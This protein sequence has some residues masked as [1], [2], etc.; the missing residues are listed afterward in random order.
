MLEEFS[1]AQMEFLRN[2]DEANKNKLYD[3][4][5]KFNIDSQLMQE[6]FSRYTKVHSVAE[7]CNFMINKCA[8]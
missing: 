6:W 5:I 4:I 7:F 1:S 8:R 2:R 3:A